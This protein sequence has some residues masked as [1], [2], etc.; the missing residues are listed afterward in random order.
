[1]VS[2]RLAEAEGE[3]H[4]MCFEDI[5]PIPYQEFQ[6]VFA[7]ESF[8]ELPNQKK[9]G[10]AIELVPESQVFNTKVYPLVPVKQKQLDDFLDENLKR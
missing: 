7:K 10:H 5:V 8:D 9:W 6:D 1:M 3:A 4:S 2:Q